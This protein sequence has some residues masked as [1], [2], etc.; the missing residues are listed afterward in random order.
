MKTHKETLTTAE[1]SISI[2]CYNPESEIDQV[3][4]GF[5]QTG[6][7]QT[8]KSLYISLYCKQRNINKVFHMLM[9]HAK[10]LERLEIVALSEAVIHRSAEIPPEFFERLHLTHFRFSRAWHEVPHFISLSSSLQSVCFRS[11]EV[12]EIEPFLL[13]KTI[14]ELKLDNNK[15]KNIDALFSNTT[16]EHLDV[17]RNYIK[18]IPPLGKN[19]SLRFLNLEENRIESL[20][21]SCADIT[22]NLSKSA[23]NTTLE[24][25]YLKN[26]EISDFSLIPVLFPSLQTLSLGDGDR[27]IE[28]IRPLA[29]L[30]FIKTVIM[31]DDML[32]IP[33]TLKV[34]QRAS[35]C[36][37]LFRIT[38]VL[39]E[40]L[41]V[42]SRCH[43]LTRFRNDR[44]GKDPRT[45][46][47]E[48]I[49]RPT[50]LTS[51]TPTQI[52]QLEDRINAQEAY[53]ALNMK[54]YAT[55]FSL[56]WDAL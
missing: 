16:L 43:T 15:I 31:N 18:S 9:K 14:R 25:L 2:E 6:E 28:S 17:S 13:C 1:M 11:S 56:L 24:T 42:I 49:G 52:Y 54:R 48:C 23:S 33:K 26:N 46:G 22:S 35:G 5:I 12:Q 27:K 3:V 21:N 47:T 53:N 19:T 7:L 55:L 37:D 30:K 20:T 34:Q 32:C 51:R 44:F 38:Y 50:R 29:D 4:R 10:C 40:I 8:K 39:E 41:W 45:H 36:Y